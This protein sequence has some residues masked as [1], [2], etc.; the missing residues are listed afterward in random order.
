MSLASCSGDIQDEPDI[1]TYRDTGAL[2][3]RSDAEGHTSMSIRFGNCLSCNQVATPAC[4]AT[5]AGTQINVRSTLD[6]ETRNTPDLCPAGCTFAVAT[7]EV[8]GLSS[9]EYDISHGADSAA[10]TLP[11]AGELAPYGGNACDR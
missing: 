8:P 2:C 10:V 4:S 11:L 9:G 5:V 7:C 3:L 1:A 6:V